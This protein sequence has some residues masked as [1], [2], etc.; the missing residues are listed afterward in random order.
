MFSLK[1]LDFLHVGSN[2]LE[3]IAEASSAW[4]ALQI[5]IAEGNHIHTFHARSACSQA[6]SC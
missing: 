6:W 4:P 2:R 5:F 3:N 1:E